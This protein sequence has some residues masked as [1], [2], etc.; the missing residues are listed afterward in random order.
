MYC[1]SCGK[2]NEDGARFC[3]YCGAQIAA[4]PAAQP[5]SQTLQ[6]TA[7]EPRPNGK[8]KPIAIAVASVVV[9]IA[10][11]AVAI[12]GFGM[13][14][15]SDD[16]S[17]STSSASQSASFG[18]VSE[19]ADAPGSDSSTATDPGSE[20]PAASAPQQ[21]PESDSG[22][23]QGPSKPKTGQDYVNRA[24]EIAMATFTNAEPN[25]SG[26]MKWVGS[27]ASSYI[28]PNILGIDEDHLQ[29]LGSKDYLVVAQSCELIENDGEARKY[30]VRVVYEQNLSADGTNVQANIAEV[31]IRLDDDGLATMLTVK[32]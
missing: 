1:P 3:P 16:G 17:E 15:K 11:A 28:S 27:D 24:E 10:V 23:A 12:G 13:A 19:S 32:Q 31:G 30:R 21:P 14:G 18:D 6:H 5:Q 9:A 22:I 25:G 4:P 7:S 8:G 2:Q 29:R 20:S 26:G